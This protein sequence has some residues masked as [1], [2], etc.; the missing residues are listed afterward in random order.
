MYI[1]L[2]NKR[3]NEFTED[4]WIKR[5]ICVRMLQMLVKYSLILLLAILYFPYKF[6]RFAEL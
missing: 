3:I 1:K 6:D 2:L 4:K 5:D